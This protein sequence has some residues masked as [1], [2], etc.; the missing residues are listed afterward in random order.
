[1]EPSDVP[2]A[3]PPAPTLLDRLFGLS[4]PV[5]RRTYVVAGV[6]LMALKFALDAAVVFA[7]TR[8]LLNPTTYL[9]PSLALREASLG[10]NVPTAMHATMA[11]LALPFVWVGLSMSIRRAA[12][13]G[14]S[15]WLG[16]AF[17]APIFNFVL[18]L[19]LSIAPT[20]AAA[21]WSMPPGS[22]FRSPGPGADPPT[23]L[24]R[25]ITSVLAAT[26]LGLA[27]T[28]LS[29]YGLGSY[30]SALFFLTPFAMGSLTAVLLNRD[31]ARTFGH[32]VAVTS[33][34][35]LLTG[36]AILLF[37]LEG[38]VCLLMAMPIALA[39]ALVGAAIGYAVTRY[40]RS[41]AAQMVGC[42]VVGLPGFAALE[43]K[44][45]HPT[46]RE[47]V[48]VVEVDAPPEVVWR[49]VV[50]F[51]ELPAPPEWFF[52][53]GIA[54]PM[55]ARIEGEGVGAVRHCEFSTGPF[56]EPI[57]RWEPPRRL[58]FDVRSQPPSMKEL[59]PYRHVD[60]PHLEG[61]MVSR[62]GEFRLTALPGGRTR[63]EGSTWYTLAIYPEAYWVVG[64]EALL[65][66]IHTRVLRHI[67]HLSERP[68]AV[69]AR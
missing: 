53:L 65:H 61:Y 9:L 47:A 49:N 19:V 12:N 20:K 60:A 46:L 2:P 68:A 66:A 40:G 30:G 13:A 56:V 1:M 41:N 69:A 26:A 34:A 22:P 5:D 36:S 64:G 48:S 67:K 14:L 7:F 50:S 63:L 16:T 62:R 18:L 33:L 27:M 23:P 59:S 58:S 6:S 8:R 4:A 54:Y 24:G 3:A 39:L 42:F 15:P 35:V 43:L 29:V 52:R 38:L 37:A 31:G 17:L 11:M 44:V 10:D 25:S 57:T 51:S 32:T 45:A 28:A 55:R 21:S